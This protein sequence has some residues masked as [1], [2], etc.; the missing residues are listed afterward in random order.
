[1]IFIHH[2]LF[3]HDPHHHPYAHQKD[4]LP[5][6]IKQSGISLLIILLSFGLNYVISVMLS[7]GLGPSIYGEY[8]VIISTVQFCSLFILL[9]ADLAIT[10]F[11]PEYLA[12]AD[13]NMARGYLQRHFKMIATISVIVLLL[14]I[15]IAIAVN[16]FRDAV[17]IEQETYLHPVISYLWLIPLFALALFF[18]K[19]LRATN[20]YLLS[21]IPFTI[22]FPLLFISGL[23]LYI[24]YYGFA[25]IHQAIFILLFSMLLQTLGQIAA[26][27]F[28]LPQQIRLALP[29]YQNKIWIN[30][31]IK[32]MFSGLISIYLYSI[33]LILLNL[34]DPQKADVGVFSAILTIC[35]TMWLAFQAIMMI[36]A[37]NISP[38]AKSNDKKTLRKYIRIGTSIITGANILL[39]ILFIAFGKAILSHFGPD[40]E[41]GYTSL[42]IVA[43]GMLLSSC[44]CLALPVLQYSGNQD[45]LIKVVIQTAILLLF[46][47]F[48]LVKYFGLM[49][50]AITIAITELY[51][52]L[53]C[54]YFVKKRLHVSPSFV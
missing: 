47:S 41:I 43:G 2:I 23:L 48:V 51:F 21:L 40:F 54:G 46:A 1:M 34:F 27:Y 10:R 15:G 3:H 7:R 16:F 45:V 30:T 53:A 6:L 33:G 17:F 14:G 28:T 5:A 49:G 50:G 26:V 37:P 8:A 11:L 36:V 18:G 22:V 31:S 38:A 20:H 13:W 4:D 44:F 24:K 39:M 32:L 35:T 19:L 42:L 12:A 9:G 52:Q 29:K 25:T